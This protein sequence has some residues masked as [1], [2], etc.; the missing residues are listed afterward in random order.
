MDLRSLRT[1]VEVVRQG[2]FSK[3]AQVVCTTQSAVS[4][5]I[6]NLENE[7]D[8]S[9]LDRTANPVRLT[10]A[11]QI[12][13]RRAMTMLN[14]RED[15]LSELDA[16]RGL[17]R[18]V[19]RLGMPQ[20]GSHTLFASLF[21]RYR[22]LYPGVEVRLVED[23]SRRLEELVAAGELDLAATLESTNSEFETQLVRSDSVEV[24]VASDHP[25]ANRSVVSMSDLADQPFILFE[26]GF[27]LNTLIL[28][29]CHLARFNPKV[30]ARSGQVDFILALVAAQTGI[31]FLPEMVA[32]EREQAGI[33]RLRIATPG[34]NWRI[35]VIWRRGGFLSRAA[36][37]WLELL[38]KTQPSAL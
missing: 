23:G 4:K 5:A 22:K 3:A 21:V 20:L 26:D 36:T 33:R 17:E 32:R 31:G 1:L 14:E 7:L 15:L 2:S 9:L 6:K 38:T 24:L 18:G 10:D 27:G 13:Y 25:L 8:L 29:A 28:E 19:L 35:V 16:L 12:V 37:A 34:I 11:G 30:A